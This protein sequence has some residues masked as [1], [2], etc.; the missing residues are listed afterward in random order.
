M[1]VVTRSELSKIISRIFEIF[2]VKGPKAF[3]TLQAYRQPEYEGRRLNRKIERI[4]NQSIKPASDVAEFLTCRFVQKSLKMTGLGLDIGYCQALANCIVETQ[5]DGLN[6]T[7]DQDRLI[8][9]TQ[10]LDAGQMTDSDWRSLQFISTANGLFQIGLIFRDRTIERILSIPVNKLETQLTIHRYFNA[11]MDINR[12]DLA[13]IALREYLNKFEKDKKV[14]DKMKLHYHL[15]QGQHDEVMTIARLYYSEKDYQ[16]ADY[17]RGKKIAVVGPAPNEEKDATEI[18]SY[19]VVIRT[20]YRGNNSMPPADEF[21]R[22]INVS[23]YNYTYTKQVLSGED[24]SFLEDLNFAVF[25]N[26]IDIQRYHGRPTST[27]FRTM[28][29]INDHILN[30]KSQMIQNIIYDLLHFEP[31]EIKVFKSNFFMSEQRYYSSYASPTNQTQNASKLWINFATHDL[32]TQ[33]KFSQTLLKTYQI[34][35]DIQVREILKLSPEQY[36]SNISRI[37]G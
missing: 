30:G 13:D 22:K 33:F 27:T 37:Y 31:L 36:M 25:K 8:E 3:K 11:A 35:G 23:Y 10:Q 21:G 14:F 15:M 4:L 29:Q 17:I 12:Y 26:A 28:R 7:D 19:D 5:K 34:S 1:V 16:F 9:L 2:K 24:N 18:D 6:N 20:N 32:V